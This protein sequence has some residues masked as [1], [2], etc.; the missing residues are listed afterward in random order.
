MVGFIISSY[1]FDFSFLYLVMNTNVWI[2]TFVR[3]YPSSNKWR[4][5]LKVVL[6]IIFS[7]R[8]NFLSNKTNLQYFV[9]NSTEW[10]LPD[11]TNR[12]RYNAIYV[13]VLWISI[14]SF[15]YQTFCDILYIGN[16]SSHVDN[17]EK[18]TVLLSFHFL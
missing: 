11:L 5:V 12:L 18:Q 17:A 9:R 10:M 16:P 2:R 7:E 6:L 4:P 3:E 15:F 8:I 13:H 1:L 14:L